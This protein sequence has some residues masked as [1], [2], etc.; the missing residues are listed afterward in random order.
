MPPQI[1]RLAFL[2]T[3]LAY[4][5]RRTWTQGK[6]SNKEK[7]DNTLKT[8]TLLRGQHIQFNSSE[9]HTHTQKHHNTESATFAH[10]LWRMEF[11][12]RKWANAYRT[13]RTLAGRLPLPPFFF[14]PCN[15]PLRA[16]F[17]FCAHS[18]FRSIFLGDRKLGWAATLLHVLG[19]IL[20]RLGNW[21]AGYIRPHSRIECA[22]NLNVG[23]RQ[24]PTFASSQHTAC[25][26]RPKY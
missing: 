24:F 14:R 22:F 21:V 11:S 23:A 12:Y 18:S 8:F 13:E 16:T 25:L 3:F 6:K 26:A 9:A 7:T 15:L 5:S 4:I 20:S 2:F 17:N 1:L 10:A 19:S